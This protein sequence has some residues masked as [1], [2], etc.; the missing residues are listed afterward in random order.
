M[1][2]CSG[3]GPRLISPFSHLADPARARTTHAKGVPRWSEGVPYFQ[4]SRPVIRS[5][6]WPLESARELCPCRRR[7]GG[8][9]AGSLELLGPTMIRI[10]PR[11]SSTT[12]EETDM[13]A[14]RTGKARTVA[15][16]LNHSADVQQA[17]SSIHEGGK[18]SFTG[19]EQGCRGS[20]LRTLAA[21]PG[22]AGRHRNCLSDARTIKHL[23]LRVGLGRCRA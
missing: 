12:F 16:T 9:A 10:L 21:R 7:R 19:P 20:R 5:D 17:P 11:R 6:S 15:V 4:Q 2:D 14:R 8:A 18:A 3:A 22:M 23:R 13:A 1:S